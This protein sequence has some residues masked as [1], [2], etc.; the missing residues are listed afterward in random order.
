MISGLAQ[1]GLGYE[2]NTVF[3]QMQDAG[4]RPNSLS[5]TSAL[6]ACTD[7]ALLNYG[8]AIHG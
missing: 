3:R 7:M 4:I 8:K 6:S 1:N 5:I 2:A